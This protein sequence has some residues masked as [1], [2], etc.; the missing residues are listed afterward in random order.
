MG[1]ELI[2]EYPVFRDNIRFMDQTL[3]GL[4]HS[5][6]WS[7]EGKVD[8]FLKGHDVDT[9]IDVLCKS[10]DKDLLFRAEFSQPLCTAIQVA[11]VDLLAIWNITPSA[12]VGHSSGEIAAAYAAGVLSA[13]D[14]II[15]AFYRGHVC[16]TAVKKGGMAAIG[17]GK[18]E[19]SLY[20]APGV[21]VA[22]ENSGSSVTISGDLEALERVMVAVKEAKPDA[23]VRKL[24]VEMAYHSR[25]SCQLRYFRS[26]L[27]TIDHMT[28][29]GDEYFS[30]I[31]EHLSPLPPKIPFYSSVRAKVLHEAADF[32]PRYWQDNLER[33]VLF[34]SASRA[35]IA[36]S[37]DCSVHL[38]VGPHAALSGPLRQI[39]KES[40]ADI[41]YV[42][43]LARGKHDTVS[44]LQA[45]GQ[46]YSLGVKI[47]YLTTLKKVLTDLPS[48]PWHYE[49]SYW[50]ETRVQKNW[51]FRKHLPHD[52][53]GLRILEGSDL[54]P[55]WRNIL[56]ISNVP[57][58]SDHC[59]GE[60]T[61][62]PAAG[63]I[64]MAGE[65]MFQVSGT[66]DY[67]VRDVEISKALVLY[68]D[69]PVEMI[70]NFQPHRFT[71]TTDSDWFT[72]HIVSCV[73]TSWNKHCSGLIRSGRASQYVS[74][75]EQSLNRKVSSS[76]WYTT[77]A[78]VGLNYTG[79][80]A[81]L[82]NIAA[83]VTAP[84]ASADI[85]DEQEMGES[86]Y[87]MHPSTLDT[88][89]QSLFVAKVQ[90]IYRD[91]KTLFLPTFIDELYVGEGTRKAMQI[92]TAA[93]T[94][95]GTV[96]GDSY[97]ISN[98]EYV[99]SLK[100]FQGKAMPRPSADMD[101]ESN[102]LQLQWKPHPDFLQASDLMHLRSDVRN[103]IQIAERL[104]VLCIV[105]TR[106]A[107]QNL[108]PAQ[109]HF[110]KF[111]NW[112]NSEYERYQRPDYPLVEDS[113]DLVQLNEYERRQLIEEV[114]KQCE[115]AGG[116]AT[117]NAVYRGYANAAAVFEGKS[118]YLD[119]LLQDGV[120]T[121]VYSWYN[122][123]WDFKDYIQLLGHAKPQMRILEIGAGTGGLTAKFLENLQSDYGER[124]YHKYTFTDI[125]S[126]FFVAAKERF[127]DYQGIEFQ[128]L[129]ISR[130]P[131]DQGF[132]PGEYDL[133]IASNVLHATPCLHD[134]LSNARTLLK[135]DG[136]LLL[137]ELCPI[138]QTMSYVTGPFAGWWLAEEDGRA[139]R[140][141][142]SPDEWDKRLRG[143]GFSGCASV[144]LDYE[145]PYTWIANI[146]AKPVVE[147]SVSQRVTLL[148]TSTTSSLVS[149][150]EGVLRDRGVEFDLCE[151]GQELPTDQN[152]ISFMDLEEKP[153]LQDIA[154]EDL[155][156]LLQ[157]VE[158]FQEST[159]LWL[160][161]PAQINSSNPHAGQTLGLT[162]TIRSELAASLATLELDS[163]GPEA[164]EAILDVLQIVQTSRDNDSELDVDVEW[165][166]SNGT[167]N[168]G[169][170]HWIPVKE[171]LCA[172]AK[173]A[174]SK[175][176]SIHNPGLLHT[177][178]W[179]SQEIGEPAPEEVHVRMTAIGL[180]QSDLLLATGA[181]IG[182][183]GSNVFGMEGVGYVI[184]LGSRV[185]DLAV[186]DR[187]M[188]VGSDTI[189]L[190]TVIQR[191]AQLC[192][193]IPDRLSDEE[194]ATMPLAYVSVLLFLVERWKLHEN[195]SILIHGAAGGKFLCSAKSCRMI[196]ALGIGI[197]AINVAKWLG[198]EI[199][200]TVSNEEKAS[201]L[202]KEFGISRNRIFNSRDSSFLSDVLNATNGLGVDLVLNTLSGELLASSWKCVALDGAMVEL[203]RQDSKCACLTCD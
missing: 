158:T 8:D 114:R 79:K 146:I 16:K 185:T 108:A 91:F 21:R 56:R 192:V 71:S 159:V 103:V 62:F 58:L 135:T 100:G 44:F 52:L 5:P 139:D 87:M 15:A 179:T 53:L 178:E 26:L 203:G 154:E 75:R 14:A 27:R 97:G 164:A 17:L 33:P 105:E 180:N 167:L 189:G 13:K 48:Y 132:S 88:V 163:S 111:R 162:R 107:V 183:G 30:L 28:L 7:I 39:Y 45:V 150:V 113:R 160:M 166:W 51:R 118:E 130:S 95:F 168:V 170:F 29:V 43:V 68:N 153:L 98:G 57:W 93:V 117:A 173:V 193:R 60:D 11:L 177:L 137:Q 35:L 89:F 188:T 85:V 65:A 72:F 134:T 9:T 67:T 10:D 80:F 77:M 155:A 174:I 201:F 20:L 41:S 36:S 175:G 143:A 148:Q 24:Q 182:E 19:I 184:K 22:C 23:F 161:H 191:P 165:A 145:A 84:I 194:A 112:L 76:R 6:S 109:P 123:I 1:K 120:L 196:T 70:T 74:K 176:L 37:G 64:A 92:N 128:S 149:E 69:K 55:A 199:Y 186:G 101:T 104:T 83:S 94:T 2:N 169:R 147:K 32:G 140:P 106:N 46:L 86:L 63:Y 115:E 82:E 124:L 12:V 195:Q 157:L 50:A 4:R 171:D 141:F 129:D 121:G 202:V 126:G 49:R 116:W 151:W 142:V 38:E 34:H 127:K 31:A 125:S 187:V 156:R 119:I 90:G 138:T 42:S 96:R 40:S 110:E 197:C 54:T 73:E 66:R 18:Q 99:F 78:R 131:V 198:A 59:I 172:T 136:Q 25:K 181:K 152:I 133:I 190:A 61:V 122:D 200:A 47:S 3:Q 81:R 102:I 144:T